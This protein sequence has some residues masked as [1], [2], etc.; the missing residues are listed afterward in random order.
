M[1]EFALTQDEN[2]DLIA[3]LKSIQSMPDL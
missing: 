1:P 3:Y 2:R